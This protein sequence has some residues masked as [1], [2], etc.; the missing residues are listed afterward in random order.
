M[1]AITGGLKIIQVLPKP[2][3]VCDVLSLVEWLLCEDFVLP[4]EFP[5]AAQVPD[6]LLAFCFRDV[7]HV[8]T[9][10]A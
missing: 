3:F 7:P 10:W 4:A 9:V 6:V 8:L 1:S 5:R 2:D